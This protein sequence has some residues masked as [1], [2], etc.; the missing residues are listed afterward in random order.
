MH[1][2]K[3]SFN[4]K[5]IF[6]RTPGSTVQVILTTPD[7]YIKSDMKMENMKIFSRVSDPSLEVRR[8]WVVTNP[9]TTLEWLYQYANF[10]GDPTRNW[11]RIVWFWKKNWKNAIYL[12]QIMMNFISLHFWCNCFCFNI[13]LRIFCFF[14]IMWLDYHFCHLLDIKVSRHF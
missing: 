13:F 14:N 12:L 4:W 11:V 2:K 7:S 9:T 5:C 6:L 1:L 8:S 10:G 3:P